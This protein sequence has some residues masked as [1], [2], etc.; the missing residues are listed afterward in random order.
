MTVVG[1]SELLR[2]K[3]VFTVDSSVCVFVCVGLLYGWPSGEGSKAAIGCVCVVV[4]LV[5][6]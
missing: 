1:L 5:Q 3:R 4:V 2:F 6:A